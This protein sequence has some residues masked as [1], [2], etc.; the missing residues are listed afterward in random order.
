M[1]VAE[2]AIPIAEEL[3]NKIIE[4]LDAIDRSSKKEFFITMTRLDVRQGLTK[5][6]LAW[7]SFA[8]SYP[9]YP[10]GEDIQ[11]VLCTVVCDPTCLRD[12]TQRSESPK[13]SWERTV[14]Q[15]G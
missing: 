5:T 3:L 10:T 7:E 9:T 6:V 8:L 1:D 15:K 14:G 13:P 2:G 4:N 12:W 11:K